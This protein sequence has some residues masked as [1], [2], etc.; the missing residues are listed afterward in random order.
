M[1]VTYI[2]HK[3]AAIINVYYFIFNILVESESIETCKNV[4]FSP[5]PSCYINIS[6]PKGKSR[7]FILVQTIHKRD[8]QKEYFL[9]PRKSPRYVYGP[10]YFVWFQIILGI[11][12]ARAG[13]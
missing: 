4:I 9:G 5:D 13:L 3:F 10:K 12:S 1:C 6:R 7:K 8:F 2:L 11:S